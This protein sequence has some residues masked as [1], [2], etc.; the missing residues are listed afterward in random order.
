MAYYYEIN[1]K[2]LINCYFS[3]CCPAM[4]KLFLFKKKYLLQ[5]LVN[6]EPEENGG[7]GGNTVGSKT[8]SNNGNRESIRGSRSFDDGVISEIKRN[9]PDPKVRNK[10]VRK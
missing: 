5:D 4:K 1:L 9:F 2:L 8:G 10:Y 7:E 3:L 6:G